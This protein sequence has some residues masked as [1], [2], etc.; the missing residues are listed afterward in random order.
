MTLLVSPVEPTAHTANVQY[1]PGIKSFTVIVFSSSVIFTPS[2]SIS[3]YDVADFADG[4]VKVSESR[5]ELTKLHC[6]SILGAEKNVETVEFIGIIHILRNSYTRITKKIIKV[7]F[8]VT[9][10]SHVICSSRIV[11]RSSGI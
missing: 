5:V 10:V 1:D 2:L 4:H 3:L 8:S 11:A 6:P 7:E 9:A